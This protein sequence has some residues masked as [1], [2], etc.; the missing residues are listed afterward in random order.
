MS[1]AWIAYRTPDAVRNWWDDY[2]KEC[3][4]W[5]FREWRLVALGQRKVFRVRGRGLSWR[6]QPWPILRLAFVLQKAEMG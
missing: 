2:R 1:V 3:W 5:H 6:Q 4:D